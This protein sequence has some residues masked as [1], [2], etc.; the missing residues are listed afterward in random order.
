MISIKQIE[1]LETF[2]KKTDIPKTIK[3]H[4]AITYHDVP[5]I[6]L[7]KSCH[8]KGQQSYRVMC[9]CPVR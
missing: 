9:G 8:A 6:R 7:G 2:F 1:E 4:G 3:L 5:K